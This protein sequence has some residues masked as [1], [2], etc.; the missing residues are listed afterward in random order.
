ML[1]KYREFTPNPRELTL[2]PRR[3][4]TPNPGALLHTKEILSKP[5]EFTPNPKYENLRP[6]SNSPPPCI[7][8]YVLP[9]MGNTSIT[10]CTYTA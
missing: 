8:D 4:F 6:W 5:R 7:Y 3:E 1:S 10:P 9:L 2:N